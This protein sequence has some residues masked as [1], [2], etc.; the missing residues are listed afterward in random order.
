M[1]TFCNNCNRKTD[2]VTK[3]YTNPGMKIIRIICVECRINK[4]RDTVF[5]HSTNV[6]KLGTP[7]RF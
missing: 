3:T 7:P 2:S 6:K 4:N 5:Y 1:K